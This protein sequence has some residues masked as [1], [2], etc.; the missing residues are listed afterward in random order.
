MLAA[1]VD[2]VEV[3]SLWKHESSQTVGFIFCLHLP[4]QR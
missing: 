2:S 1:E 4:S 3:E